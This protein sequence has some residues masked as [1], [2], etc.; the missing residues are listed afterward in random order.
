[1]TDDQFRQLRQLLLDLRAEQ[2]A[3]RLKVDKL[4]EDCL[5]FHQFQM[6]ALSN[7]PVPVDM[8]D[9]LKDIFGA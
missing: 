2:A 1:M 6:N 9:E 8:P 7:G 3:L 5:R 4:S